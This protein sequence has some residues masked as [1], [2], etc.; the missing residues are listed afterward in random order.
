M[1]LQELIAGVMLDLNH[2]MAHSYTPS[3]RGPFDV[4]R[5]DIENNGR[6]AV[7]VL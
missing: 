2:L 5:P 1:V 4:W 3:G 6:I 7:A